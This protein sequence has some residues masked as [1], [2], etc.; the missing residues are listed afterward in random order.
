MKRKFPKK[1]TKKKFKE[2]KD[3]IVSLWDD[4]GTVEFISE[5]ELA[6]LL[7]DEEVIPL[8][9]DIVNQLEK[10]KDLFVVHK[11]VYTRPPYVKV[12]VDVIKF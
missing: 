6:M 8:A 12:M 10:E 7:G 11:V 5:E 2:V 9:G 4:F 3:E 1:L